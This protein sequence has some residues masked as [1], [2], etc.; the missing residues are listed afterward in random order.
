LKL[1]SGFFLVGIFDHTKFGKECAKMSANLTIE[2]HETA[3][4]QWAAGDP[5]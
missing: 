1:D 4:S 3:T 2:R 5:G